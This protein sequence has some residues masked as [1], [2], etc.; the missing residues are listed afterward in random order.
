MDAFTLEHSS[1]LKPEWVGTIF[2]L[3][4]WDLPMAFRNAP[5]QPDDVVLDVGCGESLFL[6]LAA[7]KGK[8]AWGIDNGNWGN[9]QDWCDLLDTFEVFRSGR[10]SFVKSNAAMLP[11]PDEM[12]HKVFTFSAFEHFAGDDDICA[13][14]EVG[15]VLKKGGVFCGTVDYNPETEKPFGPD[16]IEKTYTLASLK[17]RIIKPSGLQPVG[18]TKLTGNPV[19]IASAVFF[20]LEKS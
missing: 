4:N 13:A 17:E 7:E 15:R 14:K 9:F 11:F 8:K 3:R 5:I 1:R 10:A 6:I 19:N 18:D 16:R 2:G 12:F 20:L